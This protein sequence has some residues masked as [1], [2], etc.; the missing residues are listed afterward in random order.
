MLSL[1]AK[2]NDLLLCDLINKTPWQTITVTCNFPDIYCE[3]HLGSTPMSNKFV[4]G[5][6]FKENLTGG[7]VVGQIR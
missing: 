6:F 3:T 7:A 5:H 1:F 2:D 4:A